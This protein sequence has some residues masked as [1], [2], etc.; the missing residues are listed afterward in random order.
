MIK[1]RI[2]QI[3]VVLSMVLLL[4]QIQN[5]KIMILF[6]LFLLLMMK[7][8]LLFLLC[9][10]HHLHHFFLIKTKIQH[11]LNMIYLKKN[12]FCKFVVFV[13]CVNL[14]QVMMLFLMILDIC[15]G[16]VV[17][18]LLNLNLNQE[19]QSIELL[20]LIKMLLLLLM[21]QNLVLPQ[22]L[23]YFVV[24]VQKCYLILVLPFLKLILLMSFPKLEHQ[25][26]LLHSLI[27]FMFLILLLFELLLLLF[28]LLMMS[29]KLFVVV[30]IISNVIMVKMAFGD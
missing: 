16:V 10:Q 27:L 8:V 1:K 18:D 12:I 24:I 29:F 6:L 7:L 21:G 9:H 11:L 22:V 26:H 14:Y 19:Q 5:Y 17:Q 30:L 4:N 15:I 2:I 28:L 25:D 20:P 23:L 3:F 13:P